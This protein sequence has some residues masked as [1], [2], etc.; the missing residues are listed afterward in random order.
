MRG[1]VDVSTFSFRTVRSDDTE[2]F[3]ADYFRSPDRD[4]KEINVVTLI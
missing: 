4:F 2:K 1:A 3:L